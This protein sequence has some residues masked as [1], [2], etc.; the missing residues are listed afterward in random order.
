MLELISNI[1]NVWSKFIYDRVTKL[2]RD[3]KKIEFYNKSYDFMCI[4]YASWSLNSRSPQQEI[5][6]VQQAI[7]KFNKELIENKPLFS[8]KDKNRYKNY[9]RLARKHAFLWS[10]PN[11]LASQ[12]TII[13]IRLYQ[14][15]ILRNIKWL[16]QKT[17]RVDEYSK[18]RN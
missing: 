1:V 3:H 4:S 11:A 13:R 5:Q 9:I 10:K 8:W 15:K 16:S 2:K 12:I 6:T 7:D 18:I 14:I 17:G